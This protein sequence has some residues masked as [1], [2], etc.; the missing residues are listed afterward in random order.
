MNRKEKAFQNLFSECYNELLAYCIA[1]L[2]NEHDAHDVASEAFKRLWAVWEKNREFPTA[3]NR[4]WL[5]KAAQLIIKENGRKYK[6][7]ETEDLEDFLLFL[8]DEDPIEKKTESMQYECYIEHIKPKLSKNEQQIFQWIVEQQLPY[9]EIAKKMGIKEAAVRSLV[10]R[11]RKKI[12][13]II[14]KFLK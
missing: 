12:K 6:T 3:R 7:E 13:P 9:K 5:M 11:M 14:K 2:H 10:Y 4:G 8:R 1:R